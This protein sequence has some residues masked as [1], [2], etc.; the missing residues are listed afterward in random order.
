MAWACSKEH[1]SD[2]HRGRVVRCLA[3]GPGDLLQPDDRPGDRAGKNRAGRHHRP[4]SPGR[5]RYTVLLNDDGGIIDD[6]M[7]TRWDD[8]TLFL[9]VNAARKDVDFAYIHKKIGAVTRLEYLAHRS[10]IALQGPKAEQVM[11]V[12]YP[13]AMQMKF[14]TSRR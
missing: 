7:V 1:V 4:G 9:I 2:A 6:L 10:L 14:M 13:D 3:Y 5:I 12:F 11:T 8:H